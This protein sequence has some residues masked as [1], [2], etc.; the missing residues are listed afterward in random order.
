MLTA[1]MEESGVLWRKTSMVKS[2]G[3]DPRSRHSED[4][5]SFRVLPREMKKV[6]TVPGSCKFLPKVWKISALRSRH[7]TGA[8]KPANLIL[9]C[10]GG[11]NKKQNRIPDSPQWLWGEFRGSGWAQ[12]CVWAMIRSAAPPDS[13]PGFAGPL[14]ESQQT[15]TKGNLNRHICASHFTWASQRQARNHFAKRRC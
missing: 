7:L 5:V 14:W 8:A 3:R 1:L 11:N 9:D 12:V 4:H 10:L 13:G 6:T 15:K 2:W